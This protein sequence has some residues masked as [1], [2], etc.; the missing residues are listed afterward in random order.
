MKLFYGEEPYLINQ[1]IAKISRN[2]GIKPTFFSEEEPIENIIL[3][4]TTVS[5]FFDK[6]LIVIKNHPLITSTAESKKFMNEVSS[7]DETVELIFVLEESKLPKSLLIDFIKEN[8]ELKEFKKLSEASIIPT[9]KEIVESKGGSITSGAAIRFAAKVPNDLRTIIAEVE[10]LLNETQTITEE[11]IET[12]IGEYVKEDAFALANALTNS[13]S[14]Q[15]LFTYSERKKAGDEPTYLIGQISSVL[16]LA[17]QVNG[18]RRQGL[19]NQDISDRTKIHIFRIKKA[20]ELL[21]KASPEKIKNLVV[22]LAQL[23]AD[24]KTGKVEDQ[25]GLDNFIL[26]IVR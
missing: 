21:S 26:E 6:K 4:I 5:M 24:I 18:L 15:I 2:L 3:D 11:T 20:T 23:D 10:K 17:L 22:K 8:G 9:I 19:A 13:D 16:S 12:S 14:H 1:E 7:V 25:L